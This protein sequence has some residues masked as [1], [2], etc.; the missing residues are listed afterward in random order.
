MS[1]E[2]RTPRQPE[3]KVVSEDWGSLKLRDDAI[4]STR[5]VLADL[6]VVSETEVFGPQLGIRPMLA[7][8]VVCPQNLLDLVKGKPVVS[9]TVDF[10]LTQPGY[11]RIEIAEI[12]KPTKSIYLFENYRLTLQVNVSGV[13]RNLGYCTIAGNPVY[14]VN[15]RLEQAIEKVSA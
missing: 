4:V 7:V 2:K 1:Q 8:R 5:I 3:F 10:P 13:A 14:N 9:P 11:E 6:V 12:S 15:W